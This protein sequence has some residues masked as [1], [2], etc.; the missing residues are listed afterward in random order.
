[1]DELS[2]LG[3]PAEQIEAYMQQWYY[4]LK[5]IE[6]PT[7]TTTQTISFAKKGTITRERA[8]RELE[9]IGYDKEHIDAYMG[10]VV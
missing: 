7:W 1:R 8:I 3:L 6:R 2:R 10:T 4:E 5:E 9:I